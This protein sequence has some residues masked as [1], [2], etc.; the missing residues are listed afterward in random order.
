MHKYSL[1]RRHLVKGYGSPA[2]L[3]LSFH[4]CLQLNIRNATLSQEGTFAIVM[5]HVCVLQ[6]ALVFQQKTGKCAI[7]VIVIVAV[8]P[9]K[10]DTFCG[11]V[12]I[13]PAFYNAQADTPEEVC[14]LCCVLTYA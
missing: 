7:M 9:W 12:A 5:K 6:F 10:Q 14:I 2:I 1:S 8:Q 11:P 4:K 3:R 13:V